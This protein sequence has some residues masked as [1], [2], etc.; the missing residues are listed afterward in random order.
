MPGILLVMILAMQK[1]RVK[2]REAVRTKKVGPRP[3]PTADLKIAKLVTRQCSF[4]IDAS[5]SYDPAHPSYDADGG[6]C[7]AEM[8]MTRNS[9][10]QKLT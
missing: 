3:P 6:A 9:S 1:R 7:I 5:N 2:K 8:L 4:S 10:Q